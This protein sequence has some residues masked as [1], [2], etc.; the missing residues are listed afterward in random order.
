MPT[1]PD[2]RTLEPINLTVREAAAL[3]RMG[4]NEVY[5]RVAAGRIPAMKVGRKF[6]LPY[7]LLRKYA[8]EEARNPIRSGESSIPSA[9]AQ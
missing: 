5:A 6:L 9:A 3:L 7:A 1:Q 8:E 4:K 2:S